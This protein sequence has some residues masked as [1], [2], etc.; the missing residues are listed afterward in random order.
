[1]SD[2]GKG[3]APRP[4]PDRKKFEENWDRIFGPKNRV[5]KLFKGIEESEQFTIAAA[6]KAF[7]D[8][9]EGEP[10]PLNSTWLHKGGN[11]YQVLLITNT[12]STRQDEYPTTICYKRL[13]D[14]TIWSRPLMKWHGSFKLFEPIK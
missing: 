5:E 3:S 12:D 7:H 11:I 6:R 13:I 10:P 1:M 8:K 9:L 2:G 4:I 14:G